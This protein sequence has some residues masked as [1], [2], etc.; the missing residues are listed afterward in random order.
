MKISNSFLE[1]WSPDKVIDYL[2]VAFIASSA[3]ASPITGKIATDLPTN[4]LWL[5]SAGV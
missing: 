1:I 2:L 5:N 4:A 3:V